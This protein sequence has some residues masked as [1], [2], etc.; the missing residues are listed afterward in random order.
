M[1]PRSAREEAEQLFLENLDLIEGI[2]RFAS[3]RAAMSENDAEDFGS[4]VKVRLIDDDYAALRKFAGRCSFGTY[5]SVVIQRILLDYRILLWGKW[6]SSAEAKRLGGVAITLEK[7]IHRDGRS[8]VEALPFCKKIDPLV[9]LTDLESLAARLPKRTP[10]MR[11]V[12]LDD[13]QDELHVTSDSIDQASL[14]HD[15]AIL[16]RSAS[17]VVRAALDDF[18]E[19]DRLLLRLHYGAEMT[20]A[21]V[22]RV[23]DIPQK[24]LYRRIGRCLAVLR[25][26]L[27]S[28]GITAAAVEE[29][30]SRHNPELDF[31]FETRKSSGLSVDFQRPQR[32]GGGSD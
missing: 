30:L 31:G 27:E 18:S 10:R 4:Y 20:L 23:L 11:P 7:A 5:I 8:V 9:T 2:I 32:R 16:S 25:E 3:R 21:E 28:A 13:A 12:P 24:P 15:R 29:I 6:H 22:A 1:H 26:N 19:E 17:D 14:D